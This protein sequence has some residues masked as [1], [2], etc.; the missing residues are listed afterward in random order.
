MIN[1]IEETVSNTAFVVNY[2][3]SRMAGLSRDVYAHLWVTPES[4]NLWNELS[5]KVYPNDDLN[6]SLR[7][8]FYLDLLAGFLKAHE[9]PVF[10]DVAAGFD[11]YPFL[12]DDRGHFVE[13]DLP[14]VIEYKRRRVAAWMKEGKLPE[15]RVKHFSADL[16]DEGRRGRLKAFLKE[17]IGK[18]PSL[19]TM[20]GIT[21]YLSR[22]A[23]GGIFGMLN[24][25]QRPGSL[26]AFDHWKPDAPE[27]PV[28]VR[29]RAFLDEKFGTSGQAWN[30]FDEWVP[31]GYSA[32][33]S[34]DI[35]ALERR[36]C[37]SRKFQDRENKIPVW[38]SVLKRG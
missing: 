5:E 12:V 36:Y 7:N 24:E 34:L 18:R 37:E 2:S 35:A 32:A 8:R 14:A 21:Y 26:I 31:E 13:I 22:E 28:M 9:S 27:Y 10:V 29:L 3:R 25:V 17:T 1:P 4:V 20:Q 30:L 38:F 19:V 16:N 33:E 11:N 23:L 6:V 15:R